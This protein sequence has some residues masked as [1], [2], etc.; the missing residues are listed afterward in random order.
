MFGILADV[1]VIGNNVMHTYLHT[2]I[3]LRVDIL[4]AYK[5]KFLCCY[6][7]DL[8]ANQKRLRCKKE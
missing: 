8:N 4:Y 1:A 7:H 5:Y 2:L 3:C 6:P